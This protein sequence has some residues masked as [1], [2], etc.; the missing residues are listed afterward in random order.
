MLFLIPPQD[1]L[2]ILDTDILEMCVDNTSEDNGLVKASANCKELEIGM[3]RIF[4]FLI[5]SQMK[6][7]SNSMCF[8]R[9]WK[10]G[11]FAIC[12]AD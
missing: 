9:S 6:W 7:Q 3:S 11:L 5:L 1:G 12:M 10:V 4:E 2:Y 8:V